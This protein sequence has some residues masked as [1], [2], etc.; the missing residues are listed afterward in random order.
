M[1]RTLRTIGI[2]ALLALAI[3][4]FIQYLDRPISN[5]DRI[6]KYFEPHW[7]NAEVQM[8]SMIRD[9][10]KKNNV[11]A[12]PDLYIKK[13]R[14]GENGIAIAC[15]DDGEHYKFYILDYRV[16]YLNVLNN[17][18]ITKPKSIRY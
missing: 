5:G 12:C 10:L 18:G 17:D 7:Q 9:Q 4:K 8:E 1:N 14:D 11:S 3:I 13:S 15:T 2:V 6:S 16:G